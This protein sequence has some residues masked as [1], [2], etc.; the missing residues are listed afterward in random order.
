[1]IFINTCG[2]AVNGADRIRKAF[3]RSRALRAGLAGGILFMA[4]AG[5]AFLYTHQP[6]TIL[7]PCFFHMFTGLYCPG[8][9]S[10]RACY[11]LLHGQIGMAF[12]SNPLMVI[13]LP[14]ISLYVVARTADWV[15]TGG[16]H[17]DRKI[18]VRLLLW[19]LAAVLVYGVLRNIPVFPFTLLAPGGIELLP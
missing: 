7:L 6:G 9:G 18:S 10:G 5:A 11:Y 3:R 1:M 2:A 17:V 19:I 14:L 8:C 15:I 16:N 13:L 12:S 4:A